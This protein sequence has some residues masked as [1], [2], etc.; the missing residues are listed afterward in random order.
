MSFK[1]NITCESNQRTR[2]G[3][4]EWDP[5]SRKHISDKGKGNPMRQKKIQE[6]ILKKQSKIK[7]TGDKVKAQ[8][9]AR[10]LCAIQHWMKQILQETS[11]MFEIY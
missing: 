7:D 8:L 11:E 9:E 2:T 3:K 4:E 6:G 5:I 10:I 1:V